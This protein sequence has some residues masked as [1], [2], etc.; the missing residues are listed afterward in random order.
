MRPNP[1]LK[2]YLR[3]EK[4]SRSEGKRPFKITVFVVAPSGPNKAILG[5]GRALYWLRHWALLEFV[6]TPYVLYFTFTYYTIIY[7]KTNTCGVK[8]NLCISNL[9]S[10]YVDRLQLKPIIRRL[11]Q[12]KCILSLNMN[13]MFS[14]FL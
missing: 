13:N 12:P 9:S 2:L 8:T 4:L 3:C 6:E 1:K 11:I 5:S 7:F 10:T 14:C